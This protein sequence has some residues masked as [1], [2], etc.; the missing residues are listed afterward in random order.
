MKKRKKAQAEE[1]G[2]SKK[3]KKAKDEVHSSPPKTRSKSGEDQDCSQN[4]IFSASPKKKKKSSQKEKLDNEIDDSLLTFSSPV[5][6]STQRQ[7]TVNDA[8]ASGAEKNINSPLKGSESLNTDEMNDSL[9]AFSTRVP[10]KRK[11]A[12]RK[13]VLK[14]SENGEAHTKTS[15]NSP[16][17]VFFSPLKTPR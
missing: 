12:D 13:K 17:A 4:E 7:K 1:Q 11:V 3:A 6:T 8:T 16:L 14:E 2:L 15:D 10:I 9:L 5:A